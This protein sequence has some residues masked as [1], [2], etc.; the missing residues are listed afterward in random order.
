MWLLGFY[1]P[2]IIWMYSLFF[3]KSAVFGISTTFY[4][5]AAGVFLVAAAAHLLFKHFKAGGREA[6]RVASEAASR[7]PQVVAE[8][9]KLESQV[10]VDSMHYVPR[11]QQTFGKGPLHDLLSMRNGREALIAEVLKNPRPDVAERPPV[12][13]TPPA[14]TVFVIIGDAPPQQRIPIIKAIREAN[15]DLS[16]AVVKGAVD[17]PTHR[18]IACATRRE[19][20]VVAEALHGIGIT[21]EISNSDVD[22]PPISDELEMLAARVG[23]ENSDW[24]IK[25]IRS[26]T[27]AA[28]Q[29]AIELY[30]K[31][32]GTD[33]AEAGR[34]IAAVKNQ[35]LPRRGRLGT[36]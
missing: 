28:E 16:L 12:S 18:R 21:A 29:A 34:A 3:G 15:P 1:L 17:S 25:A 27:P 22:V 24:I 11:L 32:A 4:L 8:I 19:A 6:Y 33:P 9:A 36:A 26:G 13:N 35:I 31:L 10:N 14:G 2:M 23:S 7:R 30:A 20:E 5:W